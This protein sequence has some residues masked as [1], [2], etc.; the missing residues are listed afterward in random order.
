MR[1]WDVEG[2]HTLGVGVVELDVR[3][4]GLLLHGQNSL[5]ARCDTRCTFRMAHVGFNLNRESDKWMRHGEAVALLTDVMY[6]PF[7]P[8]TLP[9]ALV[10]RGSPI[11]MK[12]SGR[13]PKQCWSDNDEKYGTYQ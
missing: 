7:S 6:T 12:V 3:R 1:P 10:S 5:D 13:S 9:M 8:K 2:C 11:E 4:D